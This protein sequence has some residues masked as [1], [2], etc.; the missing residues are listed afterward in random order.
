MLIKANNENYYGVFLKTAPGTVRNC[1]TQKQNNSPCC[2]GRFPEV[3]SGRGWLLLGKGRSPGGRVV[4]SR[5]GGRAGVHT[6]VGL[7]R[8]ISRKT[9]C[10]CERTLANKRRRLLSRPWHPIKA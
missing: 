8:Q 3:G 5:A 6:P 2:P 10:Y 7:G 1:H 9:N 4:P